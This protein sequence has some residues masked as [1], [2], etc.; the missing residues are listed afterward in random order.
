MDK[1]YEN[2]YDEM[3]KNNKTTSYYI[4]KYLFVSKEL[5]LYVLAYFS[6]QLSFFNTINPM[7][8][9]I[10]CCH[11]AKGYNFYI[12][13]SIVMTG[14]IMKGNFTNF[15]KYAIFLIL[16]I[17][18]NYISITNRKKL[19]YT[20]KATAG[21]I[22]I[23]VAGIL[24]SSANSFSPYIL[25]TSF[26]ES[27]FTF[28]LIVVLTKG[29]NILTTNKK[30]YSLSKEQLISLS[31][32]IAFIICG[33]DKIIIFNIDL[34]IFI[35]TFIILVSSFRGGSTMGT[36]IGV[37]IGF[38]LIL[39]TNDNENLFFLFSISGLVCGILSSFSI[40]I[41]AIS[42]IFSMCITAF[43]ID[44]SLL[45]EQFS[46][47][48]I[49]AA[50]LFLLLPKKIYNVINNVS[51][52]YIPDEKAFDKIKNLAM[53]RLK[54]VSESFYNLSE[55]FKAFENVE[56]TEENET[57]KNIESVVATACAQCDSYN[58][59]WKEK[60]SETYKNVVEIIET[61]E[62][63]N[64]NIN[65]YNISEMF[66]EDCVKSEMFVDTVN[67]Y[68]EMQKIYMKW[69]SKLKEI[70]SLAISQ[71]EAIAEIMNSV[72]KEVYED[73]KFDRTKEVLLTEN[74]LKINLKIKFIT[75]SEKSNNTNEIAIIFEKNIKDMKEVIKIINTTIGKKM[76]IDKVLTR[77]NY[78]VFVDEPSF[79]LSTGLSM[80]KKGGNEVSG[81]NYSLL[82]LEDNTS[83]MALSD[84]MGSGQV[85]YKESKRTIELLEQF[86]ECGIDKFLAVK[87]INSALVSFWDEEIFS[88]LDIFHLNLL[89][90]FGEFVKIGAAPTY[91]LREKDVKVIKS[92]SLPVGILKNLEIEKTAM[93]L[94]ADDVIVMV[95]DGVSDIIDTIG[96][97]Q[98]ISHLL[99][100]NNLKNPQD[101][102]DYIMSQVKLLNK[103]EVKDD[104]TVF[105]ARIWKKT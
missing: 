91:I 79:M 76:K 21:A 25:V 4:S 51:I 69:D 92:F 86:L 56:K 49:T 45:N 84:G 30:I 68:F 20:Y 46:A 40:F 3:F 6:G 29:I 94:R 57:N 78:I 28:S 10:I 12:I 19:T 61:R 97:D 87:I 58:Y 63:N 89:N 66:K 96:G 83:V 24:Y 48:I 95:T 42:L 9:A 7:G 55:S 50:A 101:I 53:L 23:M 73:F 22:L 1:I 82:E 32:L 15:A 26:L 75:V 8:V 18:I 35:S 85:A 90:G 81:D 88:T 103:G 17:T 98:F 99:L 13:A 102:A 41:T 72:S 54:N 52:L 60:F 37:L 43:Y 11:I 93:N 34:K 59:C 33:T 36:T 105:V 71:T 31:L 27:V 67:K 80:Y 38:M 39:T 5:L 65:I 62:K 70:R 64:S 74:F 77:D 100:V 2:N 47:S 44:V 104:L 16:A 14:Y